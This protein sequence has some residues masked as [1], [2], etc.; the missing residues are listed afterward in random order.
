[1]FG[2][3]GPAR[4]DTG[5]I[6]IQIPGALA[7]P[8]ATSADGQVTLQVGVGL[9][10][11]QVNAAGA[12]VGGSIA[13]VTFVRWTDTVLTPDIGTLSTLMVFRLPDGLMVIAAGVQTPD[14][15]AT[16]FSATSPFSSLTGN[17]DITIGQTPNDALV[18]FTYDTNSHIKETGL[19]R[20]V[21][22]NGLSAIQT[23]SIPAVGSVD[24]VRN[25]PVFDVTANNAKGV[26]IGNLAGHTASSIVGHPG[27]FVEL[28]VIRMI[29]ANLY[30]L[31]GC[32]APTGSGVTCLVGATGFATHLSGQIGEIPGSLRKDVISGV[33]D[34][35]LVIELNAQ[36]P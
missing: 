22:V 4:A 21:A 15:L 8:S 18:T 25:V 3:I 12:P 11:F 9:P 24:A 30:L 6:R 35:D 27:E 14:G 29:Q 1:V 23:K 26:S 34:A 5:T 13:T 17:W 10:V 7:S 33:T 32:A 2:A 20:F 19:L 36:F 28:K 16:S 31:Y